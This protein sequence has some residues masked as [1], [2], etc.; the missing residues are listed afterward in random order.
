MCQHVSIL[1]K[2]AH[3]APK[4]HQLQWVGT[5]LQ[6]VEGA[7][8]DFVGYSTSGFVADLLGRRS[9]MAGYFGLG[10]VLCCVCAIMVTF[11]AIDAI[12][13]WFMLVAFLTKVNISG[14]F[15]Q[16]Y[17]YTPEAFTTGTRNTALGVCAAFSR[18][19]AIFTPMLAQYLL[20][21][22]SGLATFGTFAGVCVAGVLVAVLLPFD[23]LG[24]DPDAPDAPEQR[25]R[26]AS[27]WFGFGGKK[28]SESSPLIPS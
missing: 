8:G 12:W 19:G 7:L 4:P 13:G 20:A 14:A 23:T 22:A 28:L 24:Y 17:V 25:R 27:F 1:S 11:G 2:A 18:I 21:G 3:S 6:R 15:L 10:G 26:L 9:A 5:L 16:L